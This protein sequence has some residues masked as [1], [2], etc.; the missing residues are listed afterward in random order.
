MHKLVGVMSKHTGSSIT[1]RKQ[2]RH[3]WWLPLLLSACF[4]GFPA[5]A[6][7]VQADDRTRF[8]Q[9]WDAAA[10]GDRQ[11][12]ERLSQGLEHYTLYPYL[13]YEDYRFR[14]HQVAPAE[15]KAF[16]ER[17][18]DWAFAQGLRSAWLKSLARK[19]D[20]PSLSAYAGDVR[21]TR[22][23]C[24]VARARIETG[25][26]ASVL[27]EAQQLW[28]VGQSQPSECDPVFDWLRGQQGISH[29]LAWE[30]IRRAMEA[31]NWRLTKYLEKYVPEHERPWLEAWRD[32]VRHRYRRLDKA[33][34]WPDEAIP[35]TITATSLKRL[36]RFEPDRAMSLYRDFEHHFNWTDMQR[37]ELLREIGLQSAV[38]LSD[39]A[40]DTLAALPGSSLDG[41]LFEWWARA[42]MA[43][44]DWM[45]LSDVIRRMPQDIAQDA[46]WR[47][48]RSV[49]LEKTGDTQASRS[50]LEEL[51]TRT[52]YYGFLAADK[53]GLPYTICPVEPSRDADDM[54][55]LRSHGPVLRSL[56]LRA[57][58]LEQWAEY[59]WGLAMRTLG[60]RDLRIAAAIA[61]EEGW[62]DRVIFALGDS[63]DQRWYEW[64]FPVPWER[65]VEREAARQQ[66]DKSWVFGVMRSES[67]LAERARSSAGALGLMQVTPDTARRLA[68][69]HGLAYSGSA[70]L[71]H[72]EPNIRFGTTFM[73]ELLERFDQNPVLVSGAYNAGPEAVER[74]LRE[75]PNNDIFTWVETIPY[76]ETRDYIPRVLAFTVIYDWRLGNPVKRVSSRMPDFGSGSMAGQETADIVCLASGMEAP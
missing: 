43:R 45:L 11:A 40:L 69:R 16:L 74:W 35:R 61:W 34:T 41:Q 44:Q 22:L 3:R 37:A 33:A 75:R 47:Y 59:E 26:T 20:W 39:D 54:A 55:R 49:A 32:Q 14:R 68:G 38:D 62:Y 70:Q 8:K 5:Q 42:A 76:Y 64:R 12:F 13:L 36:A 50:L 53:L 57:A 51:S 56:E 66:L 73:R 1:Q 25:A 10:R 48:W 24:Q 31:G 19:R 63:G 60:V 27:S 72:A 52:S 30:R 4:C 2:P 58:G 71:R 28:T 18:S 29:A 7:T 6:A 17:H 65:V 21:D 46:Q 9:A 67:A 15:M 23:R